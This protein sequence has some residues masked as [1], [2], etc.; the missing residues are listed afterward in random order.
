MG[1]LMAER[2]RELG[3]DVTLVTTLNMVAEYS[4]RALDQ[5]RIQARA[6]N[7]G[8][9]VVTAHRLVSIGAGSVE[10]A[11]IYT[12]ERRTLPSASV[13]M[14]T[15]REPQDSLYRDLMADPDK[16]VAAGIVSV[17]RIGDCLAPGTIAAAVHG[18]HL[19]ARE[20]DLAEPVAPLRERVVI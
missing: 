7:L 17:E 18:G 5:K 9:E 8:V 20:F 13:V 3:R 1:S 4:V 19:Y 15:S 6:L 11:S 10:I 14:V 12:D 2:L 16:L